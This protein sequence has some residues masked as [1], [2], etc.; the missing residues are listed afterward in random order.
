MPGRVRRRRRAIS[1]GV[2]TGLLCLT[3]VCSA[4]PVPVASPR[5]P[6][7][8][9]A[10]RGQRALTLLGDR[11]R[12]AARR[13]ELTSAQLRAILLADRTAWVDPSG[14]LLY[15][16]PMPERLAPTRVQVEPAAPF[17]YDRT[18]LLHS[19][20]GSQRTIF[21]DFDGHNVTST[22]WNNNYGVD[23]GTHR[24]YSLD[25]DATTFSTSEQDAMQSI[26]QRVAEDYAPFDVDVTTQ[27][28]GAAALARSGTGDLV[29]GTRALVSSSTQAAS[30]ICGNSCG[31]VAY[32]GNFDDPNNWAYYQPAWV[33]PQQLSNGTKNIAEAIT[34]EVGHNL[35]LAHDGHGTVAYYDGH[36]MWAPIMGTGYY[37]PVVQWSRGEYTGATATQDDLD[38]ITSQGLSYRA[39]PAGSTP[40]TAASMPADTEY[41]NN[42]SD[43]DVYGLGTCSG[44]VTA[45]AT[46]A[47]NSPNLDI[48]LQLLSA[49]GGIVATDNPVSAFQ[50]SDVATGLSA[51]LAT[52]VPSGTYYLRVDG[53]GNGTANTGYTDYGSVG[54]YNLTGQC[55]DVVTPGAPTNLTATV[56]N[57]ARSARLGWQP[58]TSDGGLP[59]TGYIVSRTGGNATTLASTARS[60]T[61]TG[62]ANGATYTLTVRALNGAGPGAARSLTAVIAA[63]V[64]ARPRIGKAKAGLAGGRVTAT[65]TWSRP[66]NDGGRPLTSFRVT[67]SRVSSSGRIVQT[68][69]SGPLSAAARSYAMRL[70][71]TGNW[72]FRVRATS[73]VGTSGLSAR[74]NIVRAR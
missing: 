11:I 10:A 39:D 73:S 44:T 70:P 42:A 37:R 58:P 55:G 71:R 46:A 7:L 16:E 3:P 63:T 34:H 30:A 2:V 20:P 25:S 69:T 59:I 19:K 64:P 67:A 14:L 38:V 60:F 52:T 50:S 43:I 36:A 5:S 62:L 17:P 8:E 21:L 65:A 29:Y 6:L 31:G 35:G 74:S 61:F 22:G 24:G 45:S 47:P 1:V 33:F 26:W 40:G 49:T 32:F 56:D 18:F 72:F 9:Q 41:I 48:E 66:L 28:P 23:P 53:V 27:D 54:A 13:N 15:K 57:A 51:S 4:A 12:A 68:A